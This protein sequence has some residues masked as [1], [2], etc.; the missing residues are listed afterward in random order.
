MPCFKGVA[1][2][3]GT[4]SL[5][6]VLRMEQRDKPLWLPGYVIMYLLGYTDHLRQRK[7][8]SPHDL[9]I[10]WLSLYQLNYEARWE[11]VVGDCD[12]NCNNVNV[13]GT[14]ECCAASTLNTS[15]GSEVYIVVP[16]EPILVTLLY[17]PVVLVSL[18]VSCI[19][20]LCGLLYLGI[21]L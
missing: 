2:F 16:S 15:D 6:H 14:N 5:F 21:K 1:F 8:L 17:S 20:K 19:I 4:S 3:C 10:W 12:G 11:Q 9:Q 18:V 13:K 7:N